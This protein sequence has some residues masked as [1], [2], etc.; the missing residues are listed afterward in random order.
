MLVIR[1]SIV[2]PRELSL[3]SSETIL[4]LHETDLANPLFACTGMK[5]WL[6]MTT[7]LLSLPKSVVFVALGTPSSEGTKA[8]KYGKVAAIV[9]VVAITSMHHSS[10]G[11]TGFAFA[12]CIIL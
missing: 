9:V 8:T 12:N 4:T 6:Y 10:S 2:P 7:V 3:N 5:F 11:S 1:Y